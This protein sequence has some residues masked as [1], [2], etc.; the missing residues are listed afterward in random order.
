M[1]E[2]VDKG[3]CRRLEAV[4]VERQDWLQDTLQRGRHGDFRPVVRICSETQFGALHRI[5]K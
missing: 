2:T 1:M 4:D 3:V 5:I